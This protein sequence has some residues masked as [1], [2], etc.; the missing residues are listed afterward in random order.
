MLKI[1]KI[2]RK[3]A[4]DSNFNFL[5]FFKRKTSVFIKF[6][7]K[8]KKIKKNKGFFSG[9]RNYWWIKIPYFLR[10]ILYTV[11]IISWYNTSVICIYTLFIRI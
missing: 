10:K 7:K 11:Y 4:S 6:V 5:D 8:F 9:E 3:G 2:Y 1:H